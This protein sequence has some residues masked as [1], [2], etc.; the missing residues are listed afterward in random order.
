MH[1][2]NNKDFTIVLS[3]YG[4]LYNLK[5]ILPYLNHCFPLP[6][7][8]VIADYKTNK[9]DII[10]TVEDSRIPIKVISFNTEWP[11]RGKA[12]NSIIPFVSTKYIIVS[13]AD[14][15]FDYDVISRLSELF[16]TQGDN[17]LVG[18]KA[19]NVDKNN[20]KTPRWLPER[21]NIF[22]IQSMALDNFKKIGGF[23]PF[24][25]GWGAADTDIRDRLIKKGLK[26]VISN[27]SFFHINHPK[28]KGINNRGMDN[29]HNIAPKSK[30]D[31]VKW[32]FP[33]RPDYIPPWIKI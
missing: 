5:K 6:K 25:S 31:G 19:F 32:S 4:R 17:V 33:G 26:P 3:N 7:E 23:N 30:W 9:E 22:G 13:D 1:L 24:F 29:R 8:I 10:K 18:F 2:N 28:T 21:V 14:I 27:I 15:Y 11:F 20:N 16:K 12:I